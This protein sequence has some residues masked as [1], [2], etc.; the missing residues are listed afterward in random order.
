MIGVFEAHVS[1]AKCRD[2]QVGRDLLDIHT[3]IYSTRWPVI[4]LVV[5]WT[6]G[7]MPSGTFADLLRA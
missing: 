4:H 3:A 2:V 5:R 6:V 7:T 1:V